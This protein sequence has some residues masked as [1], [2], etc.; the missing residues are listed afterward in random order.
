M[1]PPIK[2]TKVDLPAPLGPK[3]EHFSVT[4]GSTDHSPQLTHQ[5]VLSPP[6]TEGVVYHDGWPRAHL[7]TRNRPDPVGCDK[8]SDTSHPLYQTIGA[9]RCRAGLRTNSRIRAESLARA[10]W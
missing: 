2:L 8:A 1:E 5:S 4:N 3:I 6:L 10:I 9:R 7:N